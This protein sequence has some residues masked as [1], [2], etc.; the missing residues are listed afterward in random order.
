MSASDAGHDPRPELDDG[1][2]VEYELVGSYRL[3]Q[4]QGQFELLLGVPLPGVV[5]AARVTAGRLCLVHG[6]VRVLKQRLR[7]VGVEREQADPDARVDVELHAAH[8]E[9]L[10]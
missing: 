6:G 7:V 10:L 9:W 4:P 8:R 5:D 1:L 2:V 3:A